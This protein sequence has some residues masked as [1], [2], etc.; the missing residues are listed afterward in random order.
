MSFGTNRLFR[1]TALAAA[2]LWCAGAATAL[3]A[4]PAS[5]TFHAQD[6]TVTITVSDG[7]Q[8]LAGDA[9]TSWKLMASGHDYNHMLN[10]SKTAAGLE[11]SPTE[12]LEMGTYDLV[13]NTAS[14]TVRVDVRAPLTELTGIVE[15]KAAAWGVSEREAKDRLGL[16]QT[17]QTAAID[18]NLPA[19]YYVGQTLEAAVDPSDEVGLRWLVNGA[20]MDEG[21][22]AESFT[23]TFEKPGNYV[24]TVQAMR[25]DE[26]VGSDSAW[27]T[28]A[29][30]PAVLWTVDA[31]RQFTLDAPAGYDSYTWTVGGEYVGSGP[32]LT[33]RFETPGTYEVECKARNA[34]D[35]GYDLYRWLTTVSG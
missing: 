35:D 20:V 10:V 2:V 28:V 5:V 9:V 3:T 24:V 27:T 21:P 13:I 4:D 33:Y 32:Q 22:G 11:V 25:G 26:V 31:G 15:E 12:D 34:T 8:A 6:D 19:T 18:I 7:G 29:P 14:G 16:L 23:H 17:A 30:R 1:A